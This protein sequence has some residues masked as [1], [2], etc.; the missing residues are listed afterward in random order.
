MAVLR[1]KQITRWLQEIV[2]MNER[3][4]GDCAP[5]YVPAADAAGG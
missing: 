2:A 5:P 3:V 1:R 4:Q